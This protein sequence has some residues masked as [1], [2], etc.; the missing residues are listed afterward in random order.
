LS[1]AAARLG[2]VVVAAVLTVGVLCDAPALA[3]TGNPL[4]VNPVNAVEGQKF[5]GV[6]GTIAS[7]AA[8]SYTATINWG[9]GSSVDAGTVTAE[10]NGVC[11]IG[12]T[13]TYSE[14]GQDTLT[15][16]ATPASPA[17]G[18]SGTGTATAT[19]ADA[20]LSVSANAIAGTA[21]VTFSGVVAMLTD[22]GGLRPG[23]Y[24]ATVNWGDGSTSTAA[25]GAGGGVS[26]SHTY[27]NAGSFTFTVTVS[28]E[29]SSTAMGHGTA[30]IAAPSVAPPSCSS[31]AASS[32]APFP[33][34]TGTPDERY[35]QA[36]SKDLLDTSPTPSEVSYFTS[37]LALG[38]TRAQ[39]ASELLAGPAYDSV[40]VGSFYERYLA[41][42]PSPAAAS[43]FASELG[44]GATDESVQAQ[45]LGSAEYFDDRGD[46]TNAGWVAAANCDL[47]DGTADANDLSFWGG[48]L[49]SDLTRAQVASGI[50]AS[51]EYRTLLID[52]LYER[53]LRRA[54]NPSAIG[55]WLNAG[56]TDEQLIAALVSSQEY[57]SQ[58]GPDAGTL[59]TP[60]ISDH[61]IIHLVLHR[62]A[63]LELDVSRVLAGTGIKTIALPAAVKRGALRPKLR[64]LAIVNLGH[65]RAGP[66][67]IHWGYRAHGQSLKPGRYTVRLLALRGKT[68]IDATDALTVTVPRNRH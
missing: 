68:V 26:A 43:F 61:G 2:A 65:Y 11:T 10:P 42:A 51:S 12:G 45:I 49:A 9:D 36:L 15:V 63:T 25:L 33:S 53:F 60:T 7:C 16:T 58:L 52:S 32:P 27:A 55:Y 6:V 28:D 56:L 22:Y 4:S 62:R 30:T 13:H 21:G 67:T 64:H 14:N 18:G 35:V 1:F 3:A 20:P 48:E 17:A 40:L 57:A 46:G 29:G 54:T 38:V 34:T 66:I 5:D 41:Q 50:L 31:T 37:Q 47:L 23:A 24:T 39:V 8:G 44:D 19:I 59:S